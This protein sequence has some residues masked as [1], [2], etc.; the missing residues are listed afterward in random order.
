MPVI[1]ALQ[2]LSYTEA[3]VVHVSAV[4]A[5][6]SVAG[7]QIRERVRSLILSEVAGRSIA[8]EA[9]VVDV[10]VDHRY[11]RAGDAVL[12]RWSGERYELQSVAAVERSAILA[13]FL[14]VMRT[15]VHG[16]PNGPIFLQASVTI[17]VE[18]RCLIQRWTS[19]WHRV[20][21]GMC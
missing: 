14:L 18:W 6:V 5:M 19:D 10:A 15:D 3:A 20:R 17:A 4:E 1:I 13:E 11:V 21:F 9:A 7:H 12:V 2:R 8:E 16:V